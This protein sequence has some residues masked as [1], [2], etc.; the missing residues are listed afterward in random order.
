MFLEY[1]LHLLED[2]GPDHHPLNS[3]KSCQLTVSK[4]T[5]QPF[6]ATMFCLVKVSAVFCKSSSVD[7]ATVKGP[8]HLLIPNSKYLSL[9]TFLSSLDF[10]SSQLIGLNF[11]LLTSLLTVCFE[12][13]LRFPFLPRSQ[14]PLLL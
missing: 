13:S 2:W 7:T 8:S 5:T 3:P 1:H 9:R 4:Q 10:Y 11:Q 12:I 14:V 6:S